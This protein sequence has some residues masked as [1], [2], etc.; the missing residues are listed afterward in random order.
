LGYKEI[1]IECNGPEQQLFYMLKQYAID[2]NYLLVLTKENMIR[3]FQ[4]VIV[5]GLNNK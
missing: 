4:D 2:S 5:G 3:K 1:L